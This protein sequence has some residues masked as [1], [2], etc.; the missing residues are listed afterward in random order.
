M[1]FDSVRRRLLMTGCYLRFPNGAGQPSVPSTPSMPY[2]ARADF[3]SLP[4][5]INSGMLR[6]AA[7]DTLAAK[8]RTRARARVTSAFY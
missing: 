5:S 6:S 1:V 8:R 4:R 3:G 2:M 7:D